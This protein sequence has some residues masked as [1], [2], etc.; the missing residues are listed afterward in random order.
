M[1]E[2]RS[3]ATLPHVLT[4]PK[5]IDLHCHSIASNKTS[6]AM[7]NAIHCPESYSGPGEVY[8]QA[9]RRGMDFVTLTDHDSI[10]GATQ[11]SHLSDVIV[12]EELSCWFPED[13]CKM[14]VLVYGIDESIHRE[15]QE[16]AKN[17]YEV[18]DFIE[19]NGIAHAVAH[20]IYRQNDKLERWHLERLL[21][22]FKGFEC[23][24]GAHSALHR[25]AFE[26]LLDRLD[27]EE[28]A[29]L[30]KLHDLKPRW[31]EPWVK[32]RV[33]G[34]DDH[35]LLNVGRTWTEFPADVKSPGDVLNCLREGR[36]SPG[37]ESGSSAKLA[38]TFYSVAVRYYTRHI[39]SPGATA[40]LATTILQTLAGE[41]TAPTKRQLATIAIKQKVKK[42]ARK[43]ASPFSSRQEEAG[44]KGGLIKELFLNSA[45]SHLG[46]HRDLF[47]ASEAGLP[48]L[49][50]HQQMLD[51]VKKIDR[52]VTQGIAAAILKSIDDASF[53]GL[54]DSI[55]AV[56]A[57]Q[58]VL[59][60]YYFAVFHQNKERHLLRKITGQEKAIDS[61][62]LR[63]GL[64]TDTLD[65]MNGVGRFIRDMGTRARRAGVSLKIH[66]CGPGPE[67]PGFVGDSHLMDR[68]NFS[69][70]LSRPLPYYKELALNLPPVLEILE[71]ADREQFDVIHVSTP[72]PM[73]LCGWLVSKMLRIPMIATYHTDFPAYVDKFTGDHRV[74]NGAAAYMKWF[75]SEAATV[76]VRSAA[77]RFKLL[78][79]GI[80][81][82]KLRVL[83][84]GVDAERFNPAYGDLDYFAAR[85]ITQ[86]KRLLYAGRVSVEKNLPMLIEIFR[87]L[88]AR[89]NDIVLVV[90]G[91]GPYLEEMKRQLSHAPAYFVG[92]QNDLELARLY[93]SSDLFVF[94]SRTDTL[95]QVVM[96]A[97]ASGLPAVV[98]NE[99]GPKET[100]VDEITGRV[101]G[102]TDV[103]DWCD[104]ILSLLDDEP[105]RRKMATASIQRSSRFSLSRTFDYFWAEHVAA[106]KPAQTPTSPAIH[107]DI[108]TPSSKEP[109]SL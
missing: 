50:E 53:T 46:E 56:L 29:R 4:N 37:G 79:L 10:E 31:N 59:A 106:G 26:P 63:V 34:S 72:G 44:K 22:L 57:Q 105:R 75:Y 70:L 107:L 17:I 36:C 62:N 83:P 87:R 91:D 68:I 28:I 1:P 47:K 77:Y 19:Q 98:S 7:L 8:E 69:A 74:T 96:E 33:G 24:N 80:D 5:R 12:G 54:F 102:S 92:A 14:H 51:F 27:A 48:P 16:R 97:Q 2:L 85:G 104:A 25:E 61:K 30:S 73:G 35:G 42:I 90:A 82:N 71:R 84:A 94:P 58:F 9:K 55:A 88:S 86:P 40:N 108:P 21:L 65:E 89:R 18:A 39:M 99:G 45:K 23:L 66:T 49:G 32:A 100:V 95:G 43:I 60:P 67:V 41:R 103:G 13:Q 101:L 11:I 52:D 81:E 76:F 64:F 38:H 3:Q 20:P 78:D 93:A 15:L 6:E 109:A